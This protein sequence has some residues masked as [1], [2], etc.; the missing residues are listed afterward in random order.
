[1]GFLEDIN[2]L[3]YVNCLNSVTNKQESRSPF[4]FSLSHSLTL[5][6][7]FGHYHH[8]CK[9]PGQGLNL[10]HSSDNAKS[11]TPCATTELCLSF[12]LKDISFHYE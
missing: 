1:M 12:S 8:M 6:F 9:F 7:F 5:F 10:Y 2:A 3:I 11:L 4:P